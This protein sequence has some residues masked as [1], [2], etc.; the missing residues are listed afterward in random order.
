MLIILGFQLASVQVWSEGSS[1][2]P[3][4]QITC[5]FTLPQLPLKAIFI[6][7]SCFTDRLECI[8]Q[9][10]CLVIVL[11]PSELGQEGMV[12]HVEE[13]LASS[14]RLRSQGKS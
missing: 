10:S 9:K 7:L 13:N 12:G 5:L 4:P 8:F 14:T 3:Y 1:P 2:F 11:C 6:F